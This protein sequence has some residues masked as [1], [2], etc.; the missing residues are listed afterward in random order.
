MK[1]FIMFAVLAFGLSQA[2]V[3]AAYSLT[4][5]VADTQAHS[6][7][8]MMHHQLYGD[9]LVF[10]GQ[11]W[12]DTNP[13]VP[14]QPNPLIA[15]CLDYDDILSTKSVSYDLGSSA[16]WPS[17]LKAL[18]SLA[19]PSVW[20][21]SVSL[22][23]AAAFQLAVWEITEETSGVLDAGS[24]NFYAV[25]SL[26]PAVA[27]ANAWLA[28]VGNPSNQSGNFDTLVPVPGQTGGQ[29]QA[30]P[31]LTER[32]VVGTVPEPAT[33]CIWA[34]LA[35]LGGACHYRRRRRDG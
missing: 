28:G 26:D 14:G 24:G 18:V 31:I 33:A 15:Y 30:I 25:N 13:T 35:L 8:T 11:Y 21:Q 20:T 32:G 29:P 1:R 5:N 6:I 3:Q 22:V 7:Q 27:K 19:G 16:G 2:E 4:W 34:G 9:E 12:F 10:L 23:D 17:E